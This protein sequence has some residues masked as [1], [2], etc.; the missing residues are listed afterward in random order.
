MQTSRAAP[1]GG[2][3]AGAAP[4][5][6]KAH[7][8]LY[9]PCKTIQ[10][11]YD[12][13]GSAFTTP[14]AGTV[15]P[16]TK[17]STVFR[18]RAILFDF[19]GTLAAPALDFSLLRQ[20]ALEALAPFGVAPVDS[21]E[22]V[23]EALVRAC[24][25]LAPDRAVLARKAALAAIEAVEVE[26]AGR[27]GLFPFV[28]PML[29]MLHARGVACAVVT[30]NCAA[31]VYRVFPDLDACCACVLTRDDVE[32]VK[33]HP[34]HIG[35]ALVCL[36]CLP[37]ESV[38]VGDHPMDIEAGRRAGTVTAAVLTG[39]CGREELAGAAPDYLA[40]TAGELMRDLGL[41]EDVSG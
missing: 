31:A 9:P 26:A 5:G 27:S 20:R 39:D 28:R 17:R 25:S 8:F 30:R 22:F 10:E 37:G 7:T 1:G 13:H 19:D 2:L 21:K 23:M 11:K 29:D 41:V 4:L 38:M 6:V 35:K 32:R 33:P 18:P 15:F 24:A 14:L 36:G 3:R 12:W 40:E 16:M 34:E